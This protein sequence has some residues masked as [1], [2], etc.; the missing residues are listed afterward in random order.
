MGGGSQRDPILTDN[1]KT[2]PREKKG[3]KGN[4]KK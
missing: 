1:D 2:Y 3:T 4:I